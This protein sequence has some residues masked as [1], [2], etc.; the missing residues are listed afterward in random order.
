MEFDLRHPMV[1]QEPSISCR[2]LTVD[3]HDRFTIFILQMPSVHEKSTSFEL[4][5]CF[6]ELPKTKETESTANRVEDGRGGTRN[7]NL[8]VLDDEYSIEPLAPRRALLVFA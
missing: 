2:P 5:T 4:V 8:C 3:R 1:R 6:Q 7:G